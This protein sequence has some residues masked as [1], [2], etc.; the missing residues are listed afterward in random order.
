MMTGH[1]TSALLVVVACVAPMAIVGCRGGEETPQPKDTEP[2]PK[3]PDTTGTKPPAKKI[4]KPIFGATRPS[5]LPAPAAVAKHDAPLPTP[6]TQPTF[7]KDARSD[8]PDAVD[9]P[10]Y[11]KPAR[12]NH[13]WIKFESVRTATSDQLDRIVGNAQLD[14]IKPYRVKKAASCAYRHMERP[15]QVVRVLVMETLIPEDAY[16]LFS[17]LATGVESKDK[18]LTLRIESQGTKAVAHTWKERHYVQLTATGLASAEA[19]DYLGV[20]RE[21]TFRM[22]DAKQPALV[23]ALPTDQGL[24]ARFWFIRDLASL[25]GP[26]AEAIA[27][28]NDVPLARL[29]GLDSD[30]EMAIG[31]Y[32]IPNARRPHLLWAV[33]YDKPEQAK[34]IHKRYQEYLDSA[35]DPWSQSTMLYPPFSQYIIGTWTAEEES[36]SMLLPKLRTSLE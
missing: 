13:D 12:I 7:L 25:A 9:T 18:G 14:I 4:P 31:A 32:R 16:G 3:I 15:Q 10:A 1:R 5:T 19:K 21:I 26:G 17:V 28:P 35:A 33:R 22:P 23:R 8:I 29:L 30:A 24:A 2:V 27:L 6:A 11:L 20:L 34:A 36:L